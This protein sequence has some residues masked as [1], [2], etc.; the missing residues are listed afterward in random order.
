MF[1][2]FK[3]A[4]QRQFKA[5]NGNTIFKV[6]VDKD[7]LWQTYLNSFPEGTDPIY[8]ERTEHDCQCCKSFIRNIGGI[9]VI[10]NDELISI[11]DIGVDN[12]YQG[13]ADALSALVKSHSI[14]N[15]FMHP[16]KN[17]GV[18][19]NFQQIVDN[20]KT[21]EH[22][23][24]QLPSEL[25]VPGFDIAAK[26][27][28]LRATKDV[29]YRSL[30]E[31]SHDS[32]NTVLE[33]IGQNSLYRGEEH[34]FAVETFLKFKKEFN[35]SSNKE[36]F[37]WNNISRMPLSVS[38]IRNTSI[39][40]L[41]VDLSEGV[42]LE[43]AIASFEAKVA[44]ANYKRPSAPITK[45]MIEKAKA[46]ISELGLLNS[47]ERR[48]AV[49]EDISINN[50]LFAD[51]EVRKQMSD[52]FDELSSQTSSNLRHMDKV[53][54]IQI[55]DFIKNV[56]PNIS[57]M[58]LMLE[59]RHSNN[60]VSLIAPA[61]ITAKGMF[62]WPNPFSWSYAGEMADSIK[63]RVKKAGGKV[64]GDLCCRL[65]WEYT[66]DLDFHMH[67]PNGSH[68]YFSNRRTL[69][70]NGGMLD[71]DANGTDGARTDPAEN[72]YYSD[73]RR[74]AEGIYDLKVH[75]YSRRSDGVGFEVEVEFD[76][77]IHS[78]YY[79][80]V[81]RSGEFVS[82]AQIQYSKKDGFKIIKSLPSTQAGKNIWNIPTQTFHKV[83]L[84]LLSPNYWDDKA[85]GNKHYFFMLDK[86]LNDG[87][88][89]GF[90]NEFLSSELDPHRKVFEVV[91]SKMKAEDCDNQLSGLGFSS[92]QRNH[93]M[94]KVKG[95]FT[96]TLKIIF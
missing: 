78:F 89:R 6:Q 79:D 36:F 95:N 9:V 56:L 58:E 96:R 70:R 74:M 13:V 21:W 26:Q 65:A 91:G 37:C 62:K 88:A 3:L 17:I 10:K 83:S 68:I 49:L 50:V 72:I 48:F 22:F 66:D 40:T 11:W 44:P 93:V 76:G 32:L 33:L 82:V 71:L 87:K 51:R 75:N 5:M 15:L 69:S 81:I 90:F 85:V 25:I 18:D 8:K 94:C 47:L 27:G 55:E 7:L 73:K 41:L 4:V 30:T 45:G 80:K 23:H 54:E 84:M 20:I 38:R 77:I 14:E 34:K 67:E 1:N 39:G 31:I 59:N 46:K 52:V 29:M 28:E 92:T 12:F 64:E 86:C 63:E 24:V 42:E 16:E 61:D 2:T 35:K 19:K 53:E 57:S 60:L 43:R